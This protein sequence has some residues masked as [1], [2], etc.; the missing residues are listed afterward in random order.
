MRVIVLLFA[1]VVAVISYRCAGLLRDYLEA[2]QLQGLTLRARWTSIYVF[3]LG[4]GAVLVCDAQ[5]M[6]SAVLLARGAP[7]PNSDADVMVWLCVIGLLLT[8][9]GGYELRIATKECSTFPSPRASDHC[10]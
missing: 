6:L 4:V 9:S 5:S 2:S 3:V 8:W 1:I 10:L 7:I